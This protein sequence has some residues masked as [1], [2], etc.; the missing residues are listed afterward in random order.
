MFKRQHDGN[1]SHEGNSIRGRCEK[2]LMK[3]YNIL[4]PQDMM[5]ICPTLYLK[6]LWPEPQT[7]YKV[8]G[9]TSVSCYL[10]FTILKLLN[11]YLNSFYT[12]ICT[13]PTSFTLIIFKY[14]TKVNSV[15]V[16]I[17]YC[18]QDVWLGVGVPHIRVMCCWTCD[19]G[20]W[21]CETAVRSDIDALWA[22]G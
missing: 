21:W 12:T 9:S 7:N 16:V 11:Q 20:V 15:L 18:Y 13:F 19:W 4:G 5:E 6:I 1:T 17:M 22:Q 14:H 2:T 10:S 3:N 8:V